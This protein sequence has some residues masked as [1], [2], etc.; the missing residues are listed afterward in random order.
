RYGELSRW[1]ILD[2]P[3][4]ADFAWRSA[5]LFAM[6]GEFDQAIGRYEKFLRERPQ[7]H[8]G[9]AAWFRVGQIQLTRGALESAAGAFRECNERFPRSFDG[10]RSLVPLAQTYL[11]MGPDHFDKAEQALRQV[12]DNSN[13]FTPRAAEFVEGLFLLGDVQERGGRYEPAISTLHEALD[14]YPNDPRTKRGRFLLGGAYRKSALGLRADGGNS[15]TVNELDQLRQESARRFQA[16]RVEYR[17]LIDELELKP[18][19]ALDELE[20]M[21]LRHAYLYEADCYFETQEYQEALKLYELAAG[22]LRDTARGLAAHV[23]MI[24]CHVFLGEPREAR[25]ALARAMVVVNSMPDSA[26]VN[27]VATESRSEWKKYFEWLFASELF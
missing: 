9:P 8:R 4:S 2:E 14:R 25:T 22:N 23:Q 18:P 3:R 21:Y 19:G 26:F 17:K 16:A 7:D 24:N 1:E 6:G 5:E 27:R 15:G 13:V 10:A 20:Q 12:L 11:A